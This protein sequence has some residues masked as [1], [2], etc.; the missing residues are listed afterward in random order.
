VEFY[1]AAFEKNGVRDKIDEHI[2]LGSGCQFHLFCE[3]PRGFLESRWIGEVQ[4]RLRRG[5]KSPCHRNQSQNE[6]KEEGEERHGSC[7]G[8]QRAKKS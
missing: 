1:T 8:P 2:G 5:F 7:V 4:K 6:G 3:N